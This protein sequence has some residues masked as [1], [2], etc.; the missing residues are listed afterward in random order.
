LYNHIEAREKQKYARKDNKRKAQSWIFVR[1]SCQRM[2]Y[3]QD[4]FAKQAANGNGADG[5][6]SKGWDILEIVSGDPTK[7][8]FI[9][10]AHNLDMEPLQ[11]NWCDQYCKAHSLNLIKISDILDF[12]KLDQRFDSY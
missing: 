6:E 2:A 5:R 11:K 8:V 1:H 9:P 4:I 7:P 10:L 3:Y 12:R